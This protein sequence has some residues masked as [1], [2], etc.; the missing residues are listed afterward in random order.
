MFH[1]CL[2]VDV[3]K[4]DLIIESGPRVTRL[5]NRL[6]DSLLINISNVLNNNCK[7]QNWAKALKQALR[8]SMVWDKWENANKIAIVVN[9]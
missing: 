7:A 5:T 3:I 9:H 2:G 4:C 1:E 8:Q 6:S